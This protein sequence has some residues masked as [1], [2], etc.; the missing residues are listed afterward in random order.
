MI[1]FNEVHLDTAI[2][3]YL[4]YGRGHHPADLNFGDCMSYAVAAVAGMPLLFTGE[5]FSQTDIE[6][7]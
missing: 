1:T 5:D 6:A 7:A 2:T 3:A 4:R